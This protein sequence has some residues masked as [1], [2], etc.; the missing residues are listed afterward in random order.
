MSQKKVVASEDLIF[1]VALAYPLCELVYCHEQV[2]VAPRQLFEKPD[3]VQ[4]SNCKRPSD[5]Y[6]LEGLRRHVGLACIVPAALTSVND[7][8]GVGHDRGPIE[9]CLNALP[10]RDCGVCGVRMFPHVPR[11]VAA[12]FL[13]A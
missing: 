8:L 4:F 12:V 2:V 1:A 5:G 3:Q 10:T 9:S 11:R 6:G 7:L 13:Q